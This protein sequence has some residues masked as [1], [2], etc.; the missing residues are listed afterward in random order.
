MLPEAIAIVMAPTDNSRYVI[1]TIFS[2]TV[3]MARCKVSGCCHSFC[4]GECS[5]FLENL[6][7]MLETDDS[8][9]MLIL[10]VGHSVAGTYDDTNPHTY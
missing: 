1:L 6:I 2:V 10:A 9:S 3:D 8:L 5:V 7:K 4:R